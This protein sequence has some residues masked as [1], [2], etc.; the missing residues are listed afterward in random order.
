MDYDSLFEFSRT[1]CVAI[2]AGLVPANLLATLATLILVSLGRPPRQ[3]LQSASLAVLL[4][5]VMV[6]HV[7]T[8]LLIGVIMLPTFILLSLGSICLVINLWAII[9][10]E[11]L[12]RSIAPI[13]RIWGY[14]KFALSSQ[15]T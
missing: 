8:W 13:R 6:L 4:A 12:A 9:N 2:C 1:H 15:L 11:R 10:S 14:I 5:S 7:L 3:I